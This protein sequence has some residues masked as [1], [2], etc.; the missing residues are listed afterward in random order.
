M[1][2]LILGSFRGGFTAIKG[3]SGSFCRFRDWGRAAG[4]NGLPD[5]GEVSMKWGF[6]KSSGRMIGLLR[7]RSSSSAAFAG[8]GRM[9]P[10][11]R[12][13]NRK[14]RF[15]RLRECDGRVSEP[16]KAYAD[17]SQKPDADARTQGEPLRGEP[18]QHP[19]G[20]SEKRG[21]SFRAIVAALRTAVEITALLEME[22][23][24][25]VQ[26]RPDFGARHGYVAASR[27]GR[28]GR[29]ESR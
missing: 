1:I 29:G 16:G 12:P 2:S 10:Q 20:A 21:R 27:G 11:R 6:R 13:R 14:S 5:G 19:Y 9:H 23:L 25:G 4:R 26:G 22:L 18:F 7:H 3:V 24:H 28:R 15:T 8:V 17:S